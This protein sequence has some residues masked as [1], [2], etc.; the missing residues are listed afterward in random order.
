MRTKASPP[1]LA[2]KDP[3]TGSNYKACT[4][5]GIRSLPAAF[6][7]T[8]YAP[9]R[10]VHGADLELALLLVARATDSEL[11]SNSYLPWLWLS[12]FFH[13]PAGTRMN[14]P[15]GLSPAEHKQAQLGKYA[16]FDQL[17]TIRKSG[18]SDACLIGK[19]IISTSTCFWRPPGLWNPGRC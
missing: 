11:A 14:L 13:V 15:P 6:N 8:L 1:I 2:S 18:E 3:T 4:A 7:R 17:P 16:A 5:R 10:R 12:T 9:G 19:A